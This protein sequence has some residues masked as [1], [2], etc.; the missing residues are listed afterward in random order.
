LVKIVIFYRHCT[1]G[2]TPRDFSIRVGS[3]YRNREGELVTVSQILQHRNFN[4]TTVENDIAI[5]VVREI[6]SDII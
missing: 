5:L 6:M 1:N 3:L 4:P 2:R